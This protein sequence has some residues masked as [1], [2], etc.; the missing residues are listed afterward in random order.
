M[1]LLAV[2]ELKHHRSRHMASLRLLQMRHNTMAPDCKARANKTM[3]NLAA[4]IKD[5]DAQLKMAG[6]K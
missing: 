1:D 2:E 5:L 6:A 3:E 4:Q